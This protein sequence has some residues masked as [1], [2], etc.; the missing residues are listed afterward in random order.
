MQLG[1]AHLVYPGATHSR[2][3][4]SL[5]VF[6]LSRLLLLQLLRSTPDWDIS[7]EEGRAFLCAALIH[8]VGHYPYAHSLKDLGL[9]RHEELTAEWAV[10]S[11]PRSVLRDHLG[12]DPEL[13]AAIVDD[14]A[15]TGSVAS[16]TLF[17]QMLS[18]VLDPDKLD[19][20]NR[21]AYYCGVPYGM[22]DIGFVLSALTLVR[23]PNGHTLHMPG[24][25]VP[26]IEATLFARY[27]M[28][29][30]VYWHKTVRTATAMIKKAL[31]LSLAE[32]ALRPEQLYRLDDSGFEA[33]LVATAGP[34]RALAE[35]VFSRHLLR[36]AYQVP[37]AAERHAEIEAPAA[38][39]RLEAQLAADLSKAAGTVVLPHEL[40]ID[41]PEAVSFEVDIDVGTGG[42]GQRSVFGADVVAGFR[43]QLRVVSVLAPAEEA[44]ARAAAGLA[45][46][47]LGERV[48]YPTQAGG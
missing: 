22:Q 41:V 13:V 24:K 11:G 20:L 5:G 19:Y 48:I 9:R 45:A 37:Y 21:D 18:G 16:L 36:V 47:A 40:V 34:G 1:P 8:D 43:R 4:H 2:F 26:A 44:V 7:L 46:E 28:Y 6:H 31:L 27:L 38:R 39:L 23:G 35:R 25:G 30:T 33:L 10:R 32:G 14:K 42:G 29:R 17:R 3:G 15:R 12:V